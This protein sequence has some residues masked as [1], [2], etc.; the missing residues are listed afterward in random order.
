MQ[1]YSPINSINIINIIV[2]LAP[3]SLA[4]I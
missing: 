3:D 1:I 4:P 2:K